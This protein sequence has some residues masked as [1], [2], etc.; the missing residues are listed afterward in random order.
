MKGL[1][2]QLEPLIWLM[3]GQGIM[4]GTMLLTGWVLVVGLGGIFKHT[5][6]SCQ[7]TLVYF[8][9]AIKLLA[10]EFSAQILSTAFRLGTHRAAGN[11]GEV[12]YCFFDHV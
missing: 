1:L 9:L 6:E 12:G 3:F 11:L 5:T 10:F 4:I 2:L 7:K 8:F